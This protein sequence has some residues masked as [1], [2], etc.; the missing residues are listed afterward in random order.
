MHLTIQNTNVSK[1]N[2]VIKD[3]NEKSIFFIR[4]KSKLASP[5]KKK[6]INDENGNTVFVVRKRCFKGALIKDAAGNK[7]KLKR[8]VAGKAFYVLKAPGSEYKI[9]KNPEGNG[10]AILKNGKLIA[11]FNRFGSGFVNDRY[12]IDY[13]EACDLYIVVALI[14]AMTNIKDKDDNDLTKM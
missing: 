5:R 9:V 14:V 4:G 8:K 3:E 13:N 11:T 6:F 1:G 7:M 10:R 12:N 2:A